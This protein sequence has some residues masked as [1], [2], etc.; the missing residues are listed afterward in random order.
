[1]DNLLLFIT[2]G[3]PFVAIPVSIIWGLRRAIHLA[4]GAAALMLIGP[5]VYFGVWSIWS[6]EAL[7][8]TLIA[9][10]HSTPALALIA[11]Y[12]VLWSTAFGAIPAGLRWLW[13]HWRTPA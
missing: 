7:R 6:G 1:M 9:V 12:V 10:S 2:V 8:D 3:V 13:L 5:F 11:G 4:V